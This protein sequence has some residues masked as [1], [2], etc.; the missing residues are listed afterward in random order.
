M[1]NLTLRSVQSHEVASLQEIS[2]QTF[3]ETFA[4]VNSPENMRKYL[5]VDLSLARLRHEITTPGSRF[6]F[7]MAGEEVAG[8]LKLNTGDA[9][10]ELKT[11]DSIEIERIYVLK[12]FQGM[13]IGKFLLRAAF[14]FARREG[15]RLLWLGVWEKNHKAIGF[16]LKNGFVEFGEHIFILGD[17]E[18]RDV[19]MKCEVF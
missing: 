10:T 4:D 8:Y 2:R 11:A 3:S 15:F 5:E 7:A 18:Q 19:L 9:Q 17:E 12:Q 13:E 1:F 14:D 6:F 16:Y